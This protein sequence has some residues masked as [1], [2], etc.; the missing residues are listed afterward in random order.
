MGFWEEYSGD[1]NSL[2]ISNICRKIIWKNWHRVVNGQNSN[3]WFIGF[4]EHG[5]R[6]LLMTNLQNA[7]NATGYASEITIEILNSIFS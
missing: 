1:K 5:E 6:V 7:D 3:G 2:F 4:I